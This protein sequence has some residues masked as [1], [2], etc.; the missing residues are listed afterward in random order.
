[1]TWKQA[2]LHSLRKW[3][4]LK[5]ANQ[6][7]HDVSRLALP[8]RSNTCALCQRSPTECGGPAC[9]LCPLY[10]V[11]GRQCDEPSKRAIS[12]FCAFLYRNDARPMLYW[13]RRALK[14]VEAEDAKRKRK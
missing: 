10:K 2:L 9:T 7:K 1:M 6:I 8:I 12:P 4:G 3:E 13:L 5:K 11:R 14:Y